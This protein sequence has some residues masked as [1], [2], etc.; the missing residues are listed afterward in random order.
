MQD[1]TE[2]PVGR[3][4]GYPLFVD[5]EDRLV[6]VIGGGAIAEH[7]LRTL[8]RYGARIK[9]VSPKIIEGIQALVDEGKVEWIPRVYESGDLAGASIAFSVCGIPA[10]DVRIHEEARS[11]KCLLNV[12]DVPEECDFIVP[13]IVRR[14]L[15]SIAV[16]TSGAACTEAKRIRHR[17]ED[18]FDESWVAYLDL[19]TQVR[20]LVKERIS[21][22]HD[23]RKPIFEA[24]ADAG[25]RKRLA[26]G[27]RISVEDAYN[28]AVALAQSVSQTT[29]ESG[30]H[31]SA[32][33]HDEPTTTAT[34][35]GKER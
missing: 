27:E 18:D 26:A 35:A 3:H 33:K 4:A 30:G 29:S 19:M 34:T 22:G 32:V 2:A 11:R 28:E 10:V 6:V 15:L 7:K 1:A 9:I 20:D 21:G 31:A 12:A 5:L 16:S 8:L 25:W 17:L 13:S 23:A 14:G 24:A